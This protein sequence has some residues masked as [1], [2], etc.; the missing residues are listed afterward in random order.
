MPGTRRLSSAYSERQLSDRALSSV[1]R[2]NGK[3]SHSPLVRE[4]AIAP[5]PLERSETLLDI[6]KWGVQIGAQISQQYCAT[7]M[8]VGGYD[9]RHPRATSRNGTPSA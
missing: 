5:G 3:Y 2:R 7:I 1:L 6:Q 9:V 8:T 4:L